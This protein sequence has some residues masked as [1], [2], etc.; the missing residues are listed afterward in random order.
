MDWLRER[1]QPNSKKEANTKKAFKPIL[2]ARANGQLAYIP[3]IRVT[4]AAARQVA[5]ITAPKTIHVLLRIAGL[6]KNI[7]NHCYK[8]GPPGRSLVFRIVLFW[9]NL[10]NFSHISLVI[11]YKF[12]SL[13][14]TPESIQISYKTYASAFSIE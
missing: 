6:T 14:S 7:Y 13:F 2:G 9:R 4:I 3:I 12:I 8:C 5:T 10:N 11:L 1:R